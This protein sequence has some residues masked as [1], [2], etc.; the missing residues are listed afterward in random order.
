[1]SDQIDAFRRFFEAAEPRVRHALTGLYGIDGGRE[2]AAEAF[3]YAWEHW[4]RISV[5]ENPIGYVYVTGRSRGRRRP[6]RRLLLPV[7]PEDRTP[8]IEP[9]LAAALGALP[10][11]QRQVAMLVHAYGWSFSEAAEVLDVS[12]ATVQKHVDRAMAKLRSS[13]GVAT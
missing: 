2:A 6:A 7:P 5:M 3:A 9:K 13:L 1:M 8:M 10:P 4:E 12:K 11:R